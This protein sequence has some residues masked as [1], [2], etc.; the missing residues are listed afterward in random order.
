MSDR[1][2]IVRFSKIRFWWF[3][4]ATF[5]NVREMSN[6]FVLVSHLAAQILTS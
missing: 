4:D 1:E 6:D 3:L 5:M 2:E